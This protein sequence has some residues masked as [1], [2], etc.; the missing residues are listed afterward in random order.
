[1]TEL[2]LIVEDFSCIKSADICLARLTILIGPQ[3]SGK[4]LLSK[5]IYFFNSIAIEHRSA[6]EANV[7]FEVWKKSIC[8]R[9]VEWFP[10]SAWG[11][12]KFRIEYHLGAY[13]IRLTRS[14]YNGKLSDKIRVWASPAV[15]DFH[16][17]RSKF[18]KRL[19]SRPDAELD[20]ES[21]YK[22]GDA[23]RSLFE[24]QFGESNL[25]SQMFIPAGRSFFTSAG[26]AV[27]AFEHAKLFDPVTL[28]FGKRLAS[29][30]DRGGI[31]GQLRSQGGQLLRRAGDILG[32]E[33]IIDRSGEYLKTNDGRKIPFGS[34]SSGQQELLPLLM[35]LDTIY[36][37]RSYPGVRFVCI[38]EPEAHLFPS[39]Q[40]SLIELFAA[41]VRQVPQNRVLVTTHSPYVLSKIN[42]LIYAGQVG[43]HEK[44]TDDVRKIIPSRHWLPT[45]IVDAY[46]F[47]DGHVVSILDESGLVAA[48]YLDDV[49]GSIA[50]EFNKLLAVGVS[51]DV[52]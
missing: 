44:A 33:V 17:S 2:T 3:A 49:S 8:D 22:I 12:G 39:A 27:T 6:D 24:K 4:S 25:I 35:V 43:A 45:P 40:S 30:R 48:D 34:L 13:V 41:L 36:L 1:M 46:A 42:N 23:V 10:I 26:K 37:P 32:G 14:T 21:I 9:F 19:S 28:A 50:K 20:W 38:E 15:E 18:Q 7:A 5:L 52:V 47:Q 16:A 29:Y 31:S 51:H 11:K